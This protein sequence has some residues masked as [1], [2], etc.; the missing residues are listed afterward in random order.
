MNIAR[1]LY[2]TKLKNKKSMK[3]IINVGM[4]KV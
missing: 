2:L 3:E 1:N 4:E